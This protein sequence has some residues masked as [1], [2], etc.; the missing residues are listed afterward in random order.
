MIFKIKN[1]DF[2]RLSD[3]KLMQALQNGEVKAFD[4][5]Y[6]RYQSR[7]LYYFFRMLGSNKEIAEDFLQETFFKI[8]NKPHLYDP[9]KPF[10][11]WIFSIAHNLCKN[12]YRSRSVRS[13]IVGEENP[14]KFL[15]CQENNTKQIETE[16]IFKILDDFDEIHK[17]V[18]LLK[19]R[20]GFSI[21]EICEV[22]NIPKGTVK[23]RLHYTKLQLKEKL[24][25]QFY[26]QELNF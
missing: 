10:S 13:I 14:D 7:M 11:T 3:E 19:Y 23:S 5:I 1:I 16:Q 18:F 2:K 21:D 4:E 25:K 26:N 6:F 20:E 9:K 15:C 17:S 24:S 8:L 22:L 12:E